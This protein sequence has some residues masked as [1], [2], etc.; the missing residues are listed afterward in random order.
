MRIIIHITNSNKENGRL[1]TD[2]LNKDFS[3]DN[4]Y[5]NDIT[6]GKSIPRLSHVDLRNW[7]D[8]NPPLFSLSDRIRTLQ[9]SKIREESKDEII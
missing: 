4:S 2:E 8:S 5:Q 7:S 6:F 1:N 9:D 3:L